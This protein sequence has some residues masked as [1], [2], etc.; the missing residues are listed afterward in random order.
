MKVNSYSVFSSKQQRGFVL[1][2]CQD[3]R[4][5]SWDPLLSNKRSMVHRGR[6][7]RVERGAEGPRGLVGHGVTC[8]GG[9][10]EAGGGMGQD[11]G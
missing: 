4:R 2:R 10:A 5:A 3:M 8:A 1:G 11:R 6:Q 7:R 9:L